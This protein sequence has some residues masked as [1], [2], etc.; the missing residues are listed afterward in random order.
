MMA[1]SS[2][3]R[4]AKKPFGS[5]MSK[6]FSVMLG[7]LLS[8]TAAQAEPIQERTIQKLLDDYIE[9]EELPGG[10]LLVSMP[11]QRILV[12][13]GVADMRSKSPVLPDSRFYVASVGKMATATA[14]LQLIE[15]GKLAE[16]AAV[17]TL[18]GNLPHIEK[19]PNVRTAKL[20]QLLDHS[21]GI[22]DYLTDEFAQYY[23]ANTKRL[24]PAIVLPFAF[25]E[26]ATGR[27]GAAYEYSNSNYVLLGEI[28]AH[29]EGMS[30][31]NVMQERVLDRA[32]MSET[33]IGAKAGNSKLAR[34][35]ADL[36][37]GAGLLDVSQSAWNS[38][39]GDGPLVTTAGDLERFVFA[40]FKDGLLLNP[41][42]LARMTRPSAHESAY[43][44]GVQLGK[45]RWG[46][47]VGHD[48]MEDGFEAEV[49][50]YPDH[51]AAIIFMTNGNTITDERITD[52]TA[53]ALSKAR[54]SEK[55]P[56]RRRR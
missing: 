29:A 18:V 14:T 43:G 56:S 23:H 17:V 32:G 10:V 51:Q 39:L 35:Y 9:Q 45:T 27:P 7:L 34:G 40:L 25:G 38:P 4:L 30:F 54:K 37:D 31:E 53:I 49:R 15:E 11:G 26:T 6:A 33:T 22:P 36:D 21:S 44:M 52:K 46:R 13:S 12:V 19:L 20:S 16:G 24:T 41:S 5:S 28:M 1:Y 50:Y 8:I 3:L 2:R 48:G 55:D 47:W 42:S